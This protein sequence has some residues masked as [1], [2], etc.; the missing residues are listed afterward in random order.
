MLNFFN[1]KNLKMNM[2]TPI[3]HRRNNQHVVKKKM[4]KPL[5]LDQ[6]SSQPTTTSTKNVIAFCFLT[7]DEIERDDIW[8]KYFENV[9]PENYKIF[10]NSK[11]PNKIYRN[12]IFFNKQI[13]FPVRNTKWGE[14][15]LVTAQNALFKSK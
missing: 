8:S 15:S 6:H 11:T 5:M 4:M 3:I 1:T 14:F 12:Q 10:V 13:P 2:M 9:N 7:Y